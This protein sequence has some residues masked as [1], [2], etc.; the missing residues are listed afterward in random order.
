[1]NRRTLVAMAL[2]AGISCPAFAQETPKVDK[3]ENRQEERINNG[4]AT[5]QLTDKEAAKLENGQAKLDAKEA[6]AKSDGKVT[7]KE[8]AGLHKAE[9]KQSKKIYHEKHDGQRKH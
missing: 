4:E 7:K 6:R 1:M 9:N 3:R 5:G 8:R 2:V